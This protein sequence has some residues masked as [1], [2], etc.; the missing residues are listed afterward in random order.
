MSLSFGEYLRELRELKDLSLNQLAEKSGVSNAQI[1][2]I[3]NGLRE[4]PRP[5]TIKKLAQG[6]NVPA[7]ELM[8]KAGYFDGLNEEKKAGVKNYFQIQENL[9]DKLRDLV[10]AAFDS[11][12]KTKVFETI[13][14]HFGEDLIHYMEERELD[15]F[16]TT[17]NGII[18]FLI[19]YDMSME[20]KADFI[21][22]LKNKTRLEIKESSASYTTER[23]LFDKSL[24]LSD[25]EIKK[26][27]DFKVD[28][29]ELTEEEFAR[30]IAAVRSDRQYRED[31][32]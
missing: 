9:D 16:P 4:L 5:E 17:L 11:G 2:R 1:S 21:N 22:L 23:E 24:E 8:E 28:G 32:K 31:I 14:K 30:M 20:S 6:L 26:R 13:D 19:D 18:E 12:K 10:T 7:T 15:K 27:F 25:K 3:E 29:R